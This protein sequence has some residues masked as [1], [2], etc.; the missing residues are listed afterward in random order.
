MIERG[1][2]VTRWPGEEP[3]TEAVIR[4]LIADEGLVPYKWSNFPG[5]V[6]GA[7]S[8]GYDKVIHVIQG[9]IIFGLPDAGQRVELFAG[10]RLELPAGVKHDALVGPQGVVCLEA[11]R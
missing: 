1:V 4:E 8:H 9:S 6:Y 2:Q 10:D 3:V 7:H 5:D 11:H